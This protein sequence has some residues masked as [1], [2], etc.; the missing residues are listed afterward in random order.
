MSDE[1]QSNK[2]HLNET[3]EERVNRVIEESAWNSEYYQKEE[4]K[5][6]E[7]EQRLQKFKNRINHMKASKRNWEARKHACETII[8]NIQQ[9]RATDRTWIY[10][11][12]DMFFAAVEIWDNPELKAKPVVV[13]D[14]SMIMTASYV[15]REFGIRSGMPVFIGKKLCPDII[16]IKTNYPKYRKVS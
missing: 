13:F 3:V 7:V 10:I 5:R 1:D 16:L 6:L 8:K 15:A 2:D 9:E 14:N 11:D 12:M 4:K